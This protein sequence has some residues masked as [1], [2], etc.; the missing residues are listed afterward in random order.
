[1]T[2]ERKP[3][4]RAAVEVRREAMIAAA[5]DLIAEGGI[6]AAT[7]RA[8][9]EKAG[10]TAGLIRHYFKTKEELTRAAYQTLMER[11]TAESALVLDTAP[12]GAE[13]RLAAFVT[14]SLSPPVVDPAAMGLWA[15]FIH[16]VQSDPL[17]R[18]VHR[19]TYLGYRDVLQGL[20]ADLPRHVDAAT[21][22]AEAIACNGVIDGLWLEAC[23]LP[24]AFVKGEVV[25]IGLRSVGAILGIN[26]MTGV[27]PNG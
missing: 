14:A 4:K 15:G 12:L 21:L 25:E 16:R 17:L 11:M 10:V 13:P 22:R 26:L 20:I 7:V 8:I 1:M 24:E 23:A 5:L 9:A 6:A 18:D 27:G 2:G 3:Y 19:T